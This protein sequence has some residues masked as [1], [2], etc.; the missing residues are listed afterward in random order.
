MKWPSKW[1]DNVKVGE[2]WGMY[3]KKWDIPWNRRDT[4]RWSDCHLPFGHLGPCG[5]ELHKGEWVDVIID[6]VLLR[7]I[8]GFSVE[9]LMSCG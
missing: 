7:L 8:E 1:P 6:G 4:H 9:E 5:P 3:M 2:C